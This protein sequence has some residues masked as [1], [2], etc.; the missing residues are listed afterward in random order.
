MA[1]VPKATYY[2]FLVRLQAV[3]LEGELRLSPRQ[4]VIKITEGLEQVPV[5]PGLP[6]KWNVW[7]Q[8]P[9]QVI[10]IEAPLA[11]DSMCPLRNPTAR[12]WRRKLT[13]AAQVENGKNQPCLPPIPSRKIRQCQ[14]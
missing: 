7:T 10:E 8:G 9:Q 14:E 12:K 5:D 4:M 2:A 13:A 3:M 6:Q 1:L 11:A